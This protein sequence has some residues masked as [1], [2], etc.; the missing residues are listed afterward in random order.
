MGV[1]FLGG[2][3]SAQSAS[4]ARPG[5]AWPSG[6]P[7]RP[8]PTGRYATVSAPLQAAPPPTAT[9]PPPI[10]PASGVRA[11]ARSEWSTG[12]P[13]AAQINPMNG[14]Q[15]IT[16]HHEGSQIVRFTNRDDTAEHLDKVRRSHVNNNGWADIGYHFIVDRAGRVWEGR[17]VRYQGAHVS[18][19]N[20][21]NIG[22]MTLGNFDQQSPTQAQLNALFDTVKRLKQQH[23]VRSGNVKS[24]Q[25]IRPTACPGRNLQRH[26]DALRR[27][28]G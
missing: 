11:I 26:M 20:E 13:T 2:C 25:E 8:N 3:K 15:K 24:H 19:N 21:N 18:R 16:I 28:V 7:A 22:V 1:V 17:P 4:A 27:Y 6:Y 5:P 23:R 14:V 12:G 10:Q 9:Q